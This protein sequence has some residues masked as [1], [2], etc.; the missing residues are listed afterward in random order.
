MIYAGDEG[1]ITC[2]VTPAG[3]REVVLCSVTQMRIHPKHPLGAEIRAYQ[4]TR[5]RRLA[6]RGGSGPDMLT[7]KRKKRGR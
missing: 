6:S 1:G 7:L 3:S 2:E 5:T 4:L